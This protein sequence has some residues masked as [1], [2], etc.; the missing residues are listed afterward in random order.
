MAVNSMLHFQHEYLLIT[1]LFSTHMTYHPAAVN[2]SVVIHPKTT[3]ERDFLKISTIFFYNS[4]IPLP[5]RSF[6][7]P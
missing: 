2:E 7:H 6:A 4:T 3:F 5:S 1:S